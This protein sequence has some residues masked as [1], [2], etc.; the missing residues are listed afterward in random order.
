MKPEHCE[1]CGRTESDLLKVQRIYLLESE[2]P[3]GDAIGS[4]D[5]Q[6]ATDPPRTDLPGADPE[7]VAAPA[8][9]EYWCA[10]C[11]ATFPHSVIDEEE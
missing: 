9:I 1:S 6:R 8:D 3:S 7:V 5:P 11:C 4:T 2:D 10:S